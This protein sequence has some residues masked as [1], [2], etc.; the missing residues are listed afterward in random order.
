MIFSRL[1]NTFVQATRHFSSLGALPSA[2]QKG[3]QDANTPGQRDSL[4]ESVPSAK[5]K[6]FLVFSPG[7]SIFLSGNKS[8]SAAVSEP[9]EGRPRAAAALWQAAS[10]PGSQG[11]CLV[12]SQAASSLSSQV[13]RARGKVQP[14]PPSRGKLFFQ[15]FLLHQ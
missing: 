6:C 4:P 11:N 2:R 3:T 8:S 1:P 14:R 13:S 7:I 15:S 5:S 9:G 12:G 10:A